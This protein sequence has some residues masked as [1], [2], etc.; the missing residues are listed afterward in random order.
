MS[1][2]SVFAMGLHATVE[3]AE[4]VHRLMSSVGSCLRLDEK[5]L[6]TVLALT[7]SGTAYVRAAAIP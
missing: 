5:H 4:I 7:G 1:A 3:D 6:D 2:S